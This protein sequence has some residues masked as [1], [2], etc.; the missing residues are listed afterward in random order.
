MNTPV[1]TITYVKAPWYAFQFILRRAFIKSIPEYRQLAGLTF[2]YYHTLQTD[3]GKYFGGIYRWESRQHAENWFTEKWFSEVRRRRKTE[4]KVVYF[5]LLLERDFTQK[6]TD[7]SKLEKQS[8]TVFLHNLEPGAE[9]DYTVASPGLL[10]S[11]V[12]LEKD[13]RGALLLFENKKAAV[14]FLKNKKIYNCDIFA[15]PVLLDNQA[16]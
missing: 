12:V 15:T 1:I 11:Y 5:D 7:F 2:K 9:A 10:R 3:S 4:G 13:K 8:T 6:N 16:T 14:H